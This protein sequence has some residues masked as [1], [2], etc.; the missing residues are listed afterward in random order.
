M[1]ANTLPIPR[2]LTSSNSSRETIESSVFS[3]S[4]ALASAMALADGKVTSSSSSGSG[5]DGGGGAAH[6]VTSSSDSGGD[7]GG[8]GAAHSS[9][10]AE[11]KPVYKNDLYVPP[12][13][14]K[15]YTTLDPSNREVGWVNFEHIQKHQAQSPLELDADAGASACSSS[16]SR[17]SNKQR[18]RVVV[19]GLPSVYEKLCG[20]RFSKDVPPHSVLGRLGY[21]G[22]NVI[23]L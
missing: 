23:K 21:D 22:D 8:G 14:P 18:T 5:G 12:A 3:L 6:K 17:G 19:C 10:A 20:S 9:S 1:G 4:P 2:Q 16:C 7:G 15:E 11:D 13:L